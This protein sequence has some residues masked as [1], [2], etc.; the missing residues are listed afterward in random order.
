MVCPLKSEEQGDF[1]AW[2][3]LRHFIGGNIH[4]REY[5]QTRA[6][7]FV[8][9]IRAPQFKL[10]ITAKIRSREKRWTRQVSKAKQTN[11]LH[12]N[13]NRSSTNF[14]NLVRE[15]FQNLVREAPRT[16][17][18]S[19]EIDWTQDPSAPCCFHS[20]ARV[21][22]YGGCVNT[23]RRIYMVQNSRAYIG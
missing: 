6:P 15:N 8:V 21:T 5:K 10:K 1:Y 4:V 14:Q 13:S 2:R 23:P 22:C 18:W 3:V 19:K 12:E 9:W 11:R 17:A 20:S 16:N 7:V